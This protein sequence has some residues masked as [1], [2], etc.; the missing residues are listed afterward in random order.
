MNLAPDRVL[1][2]LESIIDRN[3]ILV[4]NVSAPGALSRV[5]KHDDFRLFATQ[6]PSGG[7]YGGKR[8]V[9]SPSLLDRFQ[10]ISFRTIPL[11]EF[12]LIVATNLG[13]CTADAGAA[14]ALAKRLTEFHRLVLEATRQPMFLEKGPYAELSIRDLLRLTNFIDA[15]CA[16]G[17][18]VDDRS[19]AQEAWAVY[20]TKFRFGV[21]G[22]PSPIDASGQPTPGGRDAVSAIM[23]QQFPRAN[24]H[25]TGTGSAHEINT[26]LEWLE[27][28]HGLRTVEVDGVAFSSHVDA[29]EAALGGIIWPALPAGPGKAI[30]WAP[31]AR[32]VHASVRAAVLDKDFF[33]SSDHGVYAPSPQWAEQW[34]SAFD[35]YMRAVP[36]TRSSAGAA[37]QG[38]ADTACECYARHFRRRDARI[39]VETA[40][41]S[42]IAAHGW[43]AVPPPRRCA[44]TQEAADACAGFVE[45]SR[46]F[47]VTPHVLHLWAQLIRGLRQRSPLLVVGPT[48]CGKAEAIKA[49]AVVAMLPLG[50]VQFTAETDSAV[51]GQFLPAAAN[52]APAAG[53]S[54]NQGNRH[55]DGDTGDDGGSSNDVVRWYDGP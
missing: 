29:E 34:R 21:G 19:L 7:A 17:V 54:D 30:E 39:D 2:A 16:R 18:G 52:A 20:G 1:Q 33:R 12:A 24:F 6:N 44:P 14:Q 25:V 28:G 32:R 40:V 5:D 53:A 26:K 23:Q 31:L 50:V 51:V 10:T 47:V 8:Q 27:G 36:P 49:F 35:V 4:K 55:R 48:G 46:P 11:S 15:A 13:S 43:G 37:A 41:N 38:F 22:M 9:L 45:A 42:I 3:Y